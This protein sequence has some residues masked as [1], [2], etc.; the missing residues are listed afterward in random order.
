MLGLDKAELKLLRR[1]N[2]PAKIQDYLETLKANFEPQDETL[3]SPRRI[4]QSGTA[5]CLEGA[6]FAAAAFWVNG[7]KPLLLDLKTTQ[8]D[9]YHVVAPF[10]SGG[11]WGA[12]SK[13]NHAVLRYREPIYHT[14]H[15]L[16]CSYFHEYFL[17]NGKKTLRS[18]AGP[19]DVRKLAPGDWLISAENL[20]MI[21]TALDRQ[22][23]QVIANKKTIAALRRADPIE[24]RA[25]RLT[26]W[27]RK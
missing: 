10:R 18:Y 17:D 21:E 20:W 7:G 27:Q 16:V 11:Y 1:L 22:P 4:I 23:H 5:H 9:Y 15:E 6:L 19:L 14:I 13:S 12:V 25:G 3:M 26:Q 24:I 2:S 8:A